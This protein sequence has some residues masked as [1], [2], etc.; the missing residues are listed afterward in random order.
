MKALSRLSYIMRVSTAKVYAAKFGLSTVAAVFKRGAN[1]LSK[2]IGKRAKSVIGVDEAAVPKRNALRGLL[3]TKYNKIPRPK[4]NKLSPNWK[5][6]YLE[7]AAARGRTK[8]QPRRTHK[9]I[10]GR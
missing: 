2:P 8:H 3:F 1:D 10:M 9:A 5:P 7:G 6:A 4:G